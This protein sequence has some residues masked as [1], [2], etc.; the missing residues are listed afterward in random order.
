MWLPLSATSLQIPRFFIRDFPTVMDETRGI[1]YGRLF[2]LTLRIP[3]IYSLLSKELA[4]R[5]TLTYARPGIPY[6][7][8]MLSVLL[9]R[10]L[11]EIIS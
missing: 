1:S 10:G 9:A 3:V 4:H 2:Y 11:L 6:K 5:M 8:T 7:S